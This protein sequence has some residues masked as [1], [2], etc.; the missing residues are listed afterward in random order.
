MTGGAHATVGDADANGDNTCDSESLPPNNIIGMRQL[1]H[2]FGARLATKRSAMLA[3]RED[4]R[5]HRACATET[6]QNKRRLAT[7]TKHKSLAGHNT[8]RRNATIVYRIWAAAIASHQ[9]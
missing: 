6:G 2:K 1:L 4:T 3:D 5:A 9:S 7:I 8:R